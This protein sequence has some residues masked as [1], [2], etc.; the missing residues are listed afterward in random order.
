[1]FINL[2]DCRSHVKKLRYLNILKNWFSLSFCGVLFFF[3]IPKITEIGFIIFQNFPYWLGNWI[4]HPLSKI[5]I[6]GLIVII[7]PQQPNA[8]NP[9][10][11]TSN[12]LAHSDCDSYF[13]L[14]TWWTVFL[15]KLKQYSKMQQTGLTNYYRGSLIMNRTMRSFR[16]I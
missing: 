16:S 10:T 15:L 1:M 6:I 11:F 14:G 13:W 9:S 8:H 3:F 12:T 4:W 2:I 7:V 5:Q